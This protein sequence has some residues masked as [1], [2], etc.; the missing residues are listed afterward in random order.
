MGHR[1]RNIIRRT[2][3]GGLDKSLR[4]PGDYVGVRA[5]S[6]V[7]A[8]THPATRSYIEPAGEGICA[9]KYGGA[10][11]FDLNSPDA[12][13]DV[14]DRYAAR[15]SRVTGYIEPLKTSGQ[16]H[17][18]TA[19]NGYSAG[20]RRLWTIENASDGMV[21]IHGQRKSGSVPIGVYGKERSRVFH[22]RLRG[23]LAGLARAPIGVFPCAGQ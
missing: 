22:E 20:I 17:Y 11:A 5:E 9:V 14:I 6:V 19:R 10:V 8:K 3:H 7:I 23:R 18:A 16:H 13:N 21:G 12:G 1:I 15:I 2:G 4:I